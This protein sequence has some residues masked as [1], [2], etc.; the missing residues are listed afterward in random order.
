MGPWLGLLNA[1]AIAIHHIFISLNI[2]RLKRVKQYA[3]FRVVTL[4]L[5]HARARP[6][7]K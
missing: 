1:Y 4:L 6:R 2:M 7:G 5:L 3:L